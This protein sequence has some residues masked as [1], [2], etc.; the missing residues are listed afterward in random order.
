[1]M[2]NNLNQQI[3][4]TECH[5]AV[6]QGDQWH[7]ASYHNGKWHCDVSV[8]Y[9]NLYLFDYS[10]EDEEEDDEPAPPYS[11]WQPLREWI[12]TQYPEPVSVDAFPLF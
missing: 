12:K 6:K 9:D 1:M 8:E 10:G 3:N 5:C 4:Q 7:D 2:N 11:E